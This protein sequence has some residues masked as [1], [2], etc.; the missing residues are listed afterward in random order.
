MGGPDIGVYDHSSMSSKSPDRYFCVIIS[1]QHRYFRFSMKHFFEF[2][3]QLSQ[4]LMG[5]CEDSYRRCGIVLESVILQ[6]KSIIQYDN[7]TPQH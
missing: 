4:K 2:R 5:L 6:T 1:I 7:Y 3:K